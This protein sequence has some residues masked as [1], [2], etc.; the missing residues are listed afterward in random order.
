M[1]V[2]GS[3]Q[4]PSVSLSDIFIMR[5][6]L[7]TRKFQSGIV[8]HTLDDSNCS[9]QRGKTV[10]EESLP[11]THATEGNLIFKQIRTLKLKCI[12]IWQTLE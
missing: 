4:A 2:W 8:G 12:L 5:S 6:T 3:K 1:S 10:Q 9:S 11:L 7:K